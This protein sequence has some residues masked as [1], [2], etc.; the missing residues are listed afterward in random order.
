MS[1]LQNKISKAFSLLELLAVVAIVAIMAVLTMPAL[2]SISRAQDMTRAGAILVEQIEKAQQLATSRARPSEIRFYHFQLPG[3]PDAQYRAIQVFSFDER[4]EMASPAFPSV[5]LPG[6][7]ALHP[8]DKF[9]PILSQ[10][11]RSGMSTLPGGTSCSYKAFQFR[12]DGSPDLP[13]NASFVTAVLESDIPSGRT[14]ANYSCVKVEP[15]TG[16]PLLYRP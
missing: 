7:V 15:V 1:H 13:A 4:G 14:P 11:P 2:R 10:A 3:Q 5:M 6:G 12:P 9:S 8:L 16:R